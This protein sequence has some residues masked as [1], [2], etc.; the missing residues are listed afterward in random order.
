MGE[1][2]CASPL[3]LLSNLIDSN[4]DPD[5]TSYSMVIEA[6]TKLNSWVVSNYNSVLSK[7]DRVLAEMLC[8]TSVNWDE[9][10]YDVRRTHEILENYILF[11]KD[12]EIVFKQFIFESAERVRKLNEK[13][14]KVLTCVFEQ[15]KLMEET[16]PKSSK[17]K[18]KQSSQ[19]SMDSGSESS[20]PSA[21]VLKSKKAEAKQKQGTKSSFALIKTPNKSAKL[22][23]PHEQSTSS[24]LHILNSAS[25]NTNGNDGTPKQKAL[26]C[27]DN[28]AKTSSKK[29]KKRSSSVLGS[30]CA[31]T[32]PQ[33]VEKRPPSTPKET[34][35]LGSVRRR[36]RSSTRKNY[37]DDDSDID[38]SPPVID[39]KQEHPPF[40]RCCD[41]D[42]GDDDIIPSPNPDVP[43]FSGGSTSLQLVELQNGIP[44][45]S[46]FENGGIDSSGEDLRVVDINDIFETPPLQASNV[47]KQESLELVQAFPQEPLPNGEK[48]VDASFNVDDAVVLDEDGKKKIICPWCQ[49][50]FLYNFQL[51]EHIVLHTGERYSCNICHKKFTRKSN[52]RQ[53]MVVIHSKKKKYPCSFCDKQFQYYSRLQAHV[54]QHTGRRPFECD[55]CGKKFTQLKN[56]QKHKALH[57][58]EKRFECKICNKT[59]RLE[60]QLKSHMDIHSD[61]KKYFCNICQKRFNYI[62][63]LCK[64]M[65]VHSDERAY[66]C[67]YCDKKYFHEASLLRHSL[68]HEEYKLQVKNSP[69]TAKQNVIEF[70]LK[71]GKV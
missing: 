1:T 23:K 7:S 56:M 30:V 17:K 6:F 26:K 34:R 43:S 48:T 5:E 29:A 64:H 15:K 49:K 2:T 71:K 62:S 14:D 32:P 44:E 54:A 41:D 67:Q 31:T 66:Q 28:S 33:S 65:D 21:P 70:A 16:R 3:E 45:L 38:S 61:D 35:S 63:H 39:I 10:D 50:E 51:K 58:A 22:G 36:L 59:F 11:E 53:H 24:K 4:S 18:N 55:V 13:K 25:S 27:N 47:L 42:H 52:L 57:T 19:L 46:S 40:V 8:Y 9:D 37:A 20:S 68:I 12:L 60:K 69:K